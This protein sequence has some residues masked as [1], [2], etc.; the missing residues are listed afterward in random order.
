LEEKNDML[1][2]KVKIAENSR[3]EWRRMYQEG[4]MKHGEV[5]ENLLKK[6]KEEDGDL[7]ISKKGGKWR[8]KYEELY[9]RIKEIEQFD[10]EVSRTFFSRKWVEYMRSKYRGVQDEKKKLEVE[11]DEWKNK[12]K[13]EEMKW[14]QERKKLENEKLSLKGKIEREEL[15]W[16][17][18][19][20]EWEREK[21]N[22]INKEI[23]KKIEEIIK[24]EE[25]EEKEEED[26]LNSSIIIRDSEEE[27]R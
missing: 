15:K 19:K 1:E 25:E 5:I 17:K 23:K 2:H 13:I 7:F 3:D 18:E 9:K 4:E 24:E 8:K 12:V 6:E 22:Y 27:E 16:N 20:Q 11:R 21:M 10:Q 26:I 14:N